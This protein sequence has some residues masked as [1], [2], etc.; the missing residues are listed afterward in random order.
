MTLEFVHVQF[1]RGTEIHRGV[2]EKKKLPFIQHGIFS[3]TSHCEIDIGTERHIVLWDLQKVERM[4]A[5][6]QKQDNGS[7]P[8][9]EHSNQD[10]DTMH[11][12]PFK[13]MGTCYDLE[14]QTALREAMLY[15]EEYNR[16]VF[17]KLLAEPNNAV[18]PNA[19]AVYVMSSGDYEKV[20]YI[21]KELTQY[22]HPVLNDP[23]LDVEVNK[24]RF[25]VAFR[26]SGFYLTIDITK[27]GLWDKTVIKA[28]KKAM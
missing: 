4:P 3:C 19:I 5:G 26:L 25:C 10:D 9:S 27:K 6:C 20:G 21:A 17:A 7:L 18:D 28:S 22:V 14:R 23:T 13:V 2:I 12:L 1:K 24:I 8:Q 11:C 15:V 16:P